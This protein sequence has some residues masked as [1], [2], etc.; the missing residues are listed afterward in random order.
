MLWSWCCQLSSFLVSCNDSCIVL[1]VLS[2]SRMANWCL[3]ATL[4]SPWTARCLF[5]E[6]D[7]RGTPGS[8]YHLPKSNHLIALMI[9]DMFEQVIKC[10]N[11][12]FCYS[13]RGKPD[14]SKSVILV[15]LSSKIQTEQPCP[16]CI[17]LATVIVS[18]VFLWSYGILWRFMWLSK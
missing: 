15:I 9:C 3:L 6:I 13:P 8:F 16:Y 4:A 1:R 17:C 5:D 11:S 14:D 18:C 12:T 10:K 2:R 7:N